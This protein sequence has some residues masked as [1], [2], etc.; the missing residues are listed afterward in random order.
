MEPVMN[1]VDSW[2]TGLIVVGCL[3]GK[4]YTGQL[5]H[6]FVTDNQARSLDWP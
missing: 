1:I 6:R 3:E 5:H 4:A 2:A